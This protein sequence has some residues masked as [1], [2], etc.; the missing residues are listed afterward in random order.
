MRSSETA[1][2][3]QAPTRAT[4][5]LE[6]LVDS[7]FEAKTGQDVEATMAHFSREELIYAD[8]AFGWVLDYEQLHG[9]Y[10][11]AMPNWGS[12]KAYAT[13]VVGDE[14]SAVLFMTCTPEMF[15]QEVLAIVA[16]DIREGKIVRWVDYMDG[17]HFGAAAMRQI[18]AA[19]P[20][21]DGE[22]FPASF[23]EERIDRVASP[24][25][26]RA[27]EALARALANGDAA[28]AAA[29]F[30]PD[31][32]VEDMTTRS[33]IRGPLALERYLERALETLPYGV[34][35]EVRHVLGSDRG[36]GFEWRR[37]AEECG[38]TCL[39]LDDSG[40]IA[41]MT[42]IWNALHMP[43][44]AFGPLVGMSVDSFPLSGR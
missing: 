31:C 7:Y 23:G 35:S 36:G 3:D 20:R 17:R 16:A 33:Q 27:V 22:S 37:G 32:V 18:E 38:I 41:R 10:S 6:R 4:P 30:A 15:G 26:E 39:E 25:I 29:G 8:A 13:R 14:R 43:D 9:I 21:P 24:G 2:G 1:P 40:A 44:D 5:D 28:G 34:G 42:S 11:Q 19:N 12:G